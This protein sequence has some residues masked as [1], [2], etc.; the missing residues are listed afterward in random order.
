M[1]EH[2]EFDCGHH[3]YEGFGCGHHGPWFFHEPWGP[4]HWRSCCCLA[5]G[6]R[7]F[8]TKEEKIAALEHY[9]EALKKEAQ[10]V[11]EKLAELRQK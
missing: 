6:F 7:R 5:W 9:L 3:E 10:A 8:W 11:E 2:R 4:R 1:R